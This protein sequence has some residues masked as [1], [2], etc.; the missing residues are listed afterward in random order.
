MLTEATKANLR[1]KSAYV[2]RVQMYAGVPLPSWVDL[3]VT[4]LCNRQCV[5]CP[6][7]DSEFYPNQ[8]L[9]M[10]PALAEKL[11]TELAGVDFHGVVVFCGYGEPLLHPEIVRL[12]HIFGDFRLEIVTNGDRL[13]TAL[14]G[15]LLEA[16]V[17]YFVVSLYDGP[18]QGEAFRQRFADAGC[19]QGS[20]LL[21]DRW[22]S[23][24]DAFGLK[25]T[26]RAGTVTVGHQDS[27]D[28]AH[29]CWYLTYQLTVDWNGD[30]LLCPQ[31]WTKRVKF[32]NLSQQSLIDV[33]TSVA[34]QK[35]RRQLMD[36]RRTDAPCN[37]CNCDGTLH[38]FNHVPAWNGTGR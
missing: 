9:H 12:A 6:H 28:Q 16:G 1:R 2:D 32:G 20:Y 7:V 29:P 18:Q 17:D 8:A 15:D 34:M 4:D 38:G 27:V 11:A 36:G 26:N 5:F 23:E 10:A 21:R 13:T 3:S 19:D 37:Q 14:I 22:H 24:A 30:V 25:L 35:R 33:W 31:D